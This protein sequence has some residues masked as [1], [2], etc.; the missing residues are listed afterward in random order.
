[1]VAERRVRMIGAATSLEGLGEHFGAG[2]YAAELDYLTR[3]EWAESAD[4][5][6]W[7]RSKLGLHLAP[8]LKS[9]LDAWFTRRFAAAE[10]QETAS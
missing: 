9:N 5:V 10:R 7:R 2:L 6:L 4:D 8:A 1:M 3:H